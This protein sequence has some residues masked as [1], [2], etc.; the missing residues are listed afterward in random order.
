MRERKQERER[1]SWPLAG[2]ECTSYL[3]IRLFY[4]CRSPASF[5][6]WNFTRKA[7]FSFLLLLETSN[8]LDPRGQWANA[9]GP[10]S[11]SFS[12]SSK[13]W[14]IQFNSQQNHNGSMIHGDFVG[15]LRG[16]AVW[17]RKILFWSDKPWVHYLIHY[18]FV[19]DLGGFWCFWTPKSSLWSRSFASS[20][21]PANCRGLAY[22]GWLQEMR[23]RVLVVRLR[24]RV[25][26]IMSHFD[27]EISRHA[28]WYHLD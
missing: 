15:C 10:T 22:R 21:D 6:L 7:S 23:T 28:C 4:F 26:L 1:E 8:S 2:P 17:Y 14:R 25:M 13:G 3:L 20:Q 11:A 16:V 5:V 12:G 27:L 9:M 18:L 24:S 19:R